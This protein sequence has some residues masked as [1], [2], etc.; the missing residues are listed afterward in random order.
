MNILELKLLKDIE[1]KDF[2]SVNT[3]MNKFLLFKL[4]SLLY[5][6]FYVRIEYYYLEDKDMNSEL[7]SIKEIFRNINTEGFIKIIENFSIT[8]IYKGIDILLSF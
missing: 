8:H 4:A 3:G 1:I 6:L 2:K 7:I 5:E